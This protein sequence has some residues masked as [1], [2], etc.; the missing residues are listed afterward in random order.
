MHSRQQRPDGSLIHSISKYCESTIRGH[1]LP[2]A[3]LEQE[4]KIVAARDL[5]S[6]N[7]LTVFVADG[8]EIS[9][10]DNI[11]MIGA[12]DWRDTSG[13]WTQHRGVDASYEVLVR[14]AGT[15]ASRG[16]LDAAERIGCSRLVERSLL[17]I[18]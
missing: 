6:L 11:V 7:S 8:W 15:V 18:L 2:H 13:R 12:D 16:P 9:T 14:L 5:L 1:H 17:L 4:G 3:W 10:G